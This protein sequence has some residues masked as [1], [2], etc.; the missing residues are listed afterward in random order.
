VLFRSVTDGPD[1]GPTMTHLVPS[2]TVFYDTLEKTYP[3][4]PDIEEIKLTKAEMELWLDMRPYMDTAPYTIE[5]TASIE[6]SYKLFRTMGLRHL[7][8]LDSNH[9]VVGIITRKDITEHTLHHVWEIE[10]TQ[11]QKHINV[12]AIPVAVVFD[13]PDH[14][15]NRTDDDGLSLSRVEMISRHASDASENLYAESVDTDR[16]RAGTVD[17]SAGLADSPQFSTYRKTL[18]TDI[19]SEVQNMT[20]MGADAIMTIMPLKVPSSLK[21]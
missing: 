7:V 12:E 5:V 4:F 13:G 9:E 2:A 18:R 10:G 15:T 8:V 1:E 16:D 6:R 19:R 20:N 21:K 3:V 17:A 14:P 11:M